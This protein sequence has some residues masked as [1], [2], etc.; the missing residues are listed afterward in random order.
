MSLTAA[1]VNLSN[2]EFPARGRINQAFTRRYLFSLNSSIGFVRL[3]GSINGP[4]DKQD[5]DLFFSGALSPLPVLQG[6]VVDSRHSDCDRC[7]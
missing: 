4:K 3:F 7:S 2:L 6:P 1:P 5:V